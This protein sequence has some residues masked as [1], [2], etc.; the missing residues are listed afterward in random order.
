MAP[1]KYTA[2]VISLCIL[3]NAI[4]TILVDTLIT[5]NALTTEILLTIKFATKG[6]SSMGMKRA[7]LFIGDKI[8]FLCVCVLLL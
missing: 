7:N 4:N 8:V 2:T 5:L 1:I 6:L 3:V